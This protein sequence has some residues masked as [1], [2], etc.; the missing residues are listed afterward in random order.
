MVPDVYWEVTQKKE[1]SHVRLFSQSLA[2]GRIRLVSVLQPDEARQ[3][4]NSRLTRLHCGEKQTLYRYFMGIEDF[5]IIDDKK[6]AGYCRDH[7][8]PYLN[9][10][11]CPKILYFS[12]IIN[13]TLFQRLTARLLKV[14]RYALWIRQTAENLSTEDLSFFL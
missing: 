7:G 14:G 3:I 5:V 1:Q 4:T 10:L 9:A 11:L 6:G 12:G 2:K 13:T 8:I